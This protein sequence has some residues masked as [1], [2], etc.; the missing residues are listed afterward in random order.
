MRVARRRHHLEH[1]VVDGQEGHVERPASEVEDED[2]LLAGL[3]LVEAVGD[4]RGRGLVDDAEHVEARDGPG[5]LGR[6][7]LRVVEVGG[8]GDHGVLDLLAKVRLR[9]LLHLGED[10]GGDLL[11]GVGL[12]LALEEHLD[13]RLAGGVD[14][15]VREQLLV[16]H[17]RGVRKLAA[18]QALHVEDGVLWV[19]DA[20]VLGG[21][22][23]EALIVG[24][25]NPRRGD[26]VTLVV[27][28]DLDLAVLV[29]ADARVGGAEVNTD[30]G[31][32]RALI[33]EDNRAAE[34]RNAR[35]QEAER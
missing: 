19:H 18:D 22:A 12:L 33:G 17:N 35:C 7:A 4:G 16:V 29:H 32:H 31:V 5:V 26:A 6:L 24:E 30:G 25:G 23:D 11:G 3:L 14:E 2:I 15:L 21:V 20:L 28:D 1:T 8:H 9:D 34:Q 10:H 13:V 27:S